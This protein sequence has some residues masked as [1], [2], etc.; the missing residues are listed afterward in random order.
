MKFRLIVIFLVSFSVLTSCAQN[1]GKPFQND[2]EKFKAAD[3]ASFPPSDA[4]LFIG[5]SSFTMWQ[6]VQSDFPGYILINRGFGGSQLTDLIRYADDVILPYHPKQVVIY[7]GDNDIASGASPTEVL[8]R[9]KKLF[10]IIRT[11]DAATHVA[12][13]TIKPSPSRLKLLPEMKKAN[14]LIRQ[15]LSG[16]KATA[17]I[18][19]VN[20]ML[21]SNGKP[22]QELFL[23][24][25]LHMNEKGYIIWQKAIRPY[26]LH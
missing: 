8:E 14:E 5:S 26:L 25:N 2:I 21:D 12:Y 4:I 6:D 7:C 10:N 23:G 15:F 20:P 18:D 19:I 24:D 1:K 9:F 13:V 11:A 17:Y 16:Y 3:Q 22:D